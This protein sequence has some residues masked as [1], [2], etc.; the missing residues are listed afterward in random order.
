LKLFFR[1]WGNLVEE[2]ENQNKLPHGNQNQ[3][4]PDKVFT[5]AQ[6][7]LRRGRKPKLELGRTD[8]DNVTIVQPLFFHL[9]A[10]DGGNG[11]GRGCHMKTILLFKFKSEVPVPNAVI[12]QRQV[13][14]GQASDVKRKMADDY[15][16]ARL[17]A[18][19]NVQINHQKIRRST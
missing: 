9:F 13:V 3:Q 17:F 1:A 12:L 5:Q 18:R 2:G 11:I 6:A 7:A 4:G 16:V 14:L 8:G 15:P 19:K 10:I